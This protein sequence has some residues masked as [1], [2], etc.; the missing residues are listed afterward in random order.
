MRSSRAFAFN[1]SS[2]SLPDHYHSLIPG[3]FQS[4]TLSFQTPDK[5][6][7]H[8]CATSTSSER[9]SRLHREPC[10]PTHQHYL[11]Q[12]IQGNC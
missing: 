10:P 3:N 11:N 5:Q 8:D 6:A 1:L 7:L 4:P 2:I 9:N 12:K